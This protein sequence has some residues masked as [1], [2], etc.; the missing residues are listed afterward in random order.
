MRIIHFRFYDDF[1]VKEKKLVC[2]SKFLSVGLTPETYLK[3]VKDVIN[4]CYSFKESLYKENWYIEENRILAKKVIKSDSYYRKYLRHI[5][6]YYPE[7]LHT[8]KI[9][10]TWY[11][12]APYKIESICMTDNETDERTEIT[13]CISEDVVPERTNTHNLKD[14]EDTIALK[15][16]YDLVVKDLIAEKHEKTNPNE[17]IWD[18]VKSII[19]KYYYKK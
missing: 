9:D 3:H 15:Y 12:Y 1:S 16:I 5:V 18:A 13:T 2:P 8:K 7:F 19:M 10:N 11:Y 14:I 17:I 6:N 4:T